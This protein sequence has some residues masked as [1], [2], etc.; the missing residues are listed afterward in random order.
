MGGWV[1]ELY[2]VLLLTLQSP[3]SRCID[4]LVIWKVFIRQYEKGLE[5]SGLATL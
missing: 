2:P 5:E 4:Y 1:G 3:L